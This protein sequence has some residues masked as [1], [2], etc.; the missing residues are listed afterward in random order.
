MRCVILHILST[1][2]TRRAVCPL[3]VLGSCMIKSMGTTTHV[4]SGI[5]RGCSTPAGFCV[6][7]IFTW[8]EWLLHMTGHVFNQIWPPEEFLNSFVCLRDSTMSVHWRS[9][10][11]FCYGTLCSEPYFYV[12]HHKLVCFCVQWRVCVIPVLKPRVVVVPCRNRPIISR[13]PSGNSV[14]VKVGHKNA[15]FFFV[16]GSD[17]RHQLPNLSSLFFLFEGVTHM[18]PTLKK[19]E[20]KRE[21]Q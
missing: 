7:L 16:G 11:L 1:N 4:C 13:V 19:I 3:F 18:C 6:E 9:V 5:G 12:W 21:R 8:Q 17:L 10:Q 14:W 20:N 15:N 2:T